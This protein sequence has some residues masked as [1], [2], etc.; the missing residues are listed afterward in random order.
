MAGIRTTAKKPPFD[1]SATRLSRRKFL[2]VGAVSA[3]A[4]SNDGYAEPRSQCGNSLGVAGRESPDARIG[5]DLFGVRRKDGHRIELGIE[6]H[7]QQRRTVAKLCIRE[8]GLLTSLELLVHSWAEVRERTACV[9]E[10]DGEDSPAP[11]RERS[12]LA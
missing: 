4:F 5:A 7:G 2:H 9:Y 3:G 1:P 11:V 12:G 6:T 8:N 10:R